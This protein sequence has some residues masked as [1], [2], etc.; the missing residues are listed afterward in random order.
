[1]SCAPSYCVLAAFPFSLVICSLCLLW[2][3][4]DPLGVSGS[5]WALLGFQLNQTR[6]FARDTLAP[7]HWVLS[8]CW[9][10]RDF[11]WQAE[12]ATGPTVCIQTTAGAIL[13]LMYVIIFS[14]PRGRDYFGVVLAPVGAACTLPGLYSWFE[15]VLA[16]TLLEVAEDAVLA[17]SAH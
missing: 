1:M 9:P 14:S 10:L 17:R 6:H 16:K 7:S 3:V 5:V 13:G 15:L 8:L 12:P 4:F 11:C 2:A